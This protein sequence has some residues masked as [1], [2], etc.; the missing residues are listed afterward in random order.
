MTKLSELIT[1]IALQSGI[2]AEDSALITITGNPTLAAIE[3]PDDISSRLTAPRL[4]MDAAKQNPDLKRHFTAQALNGVDT[5][6]ARLIVEEQLADDAKGEIESE[7]NTFKKVSVLMK[8]IQ[9]K[10]S[11]KVGAA[12]KD[13]NILDKEIENLNGQLAKLK[14]DFL[15]EKDTLIKGFDS[16]RI[17]NEVRSFVLSQN[18]NLPDTFTAEAKFAAAEALFRSELQAKGINI[19]RKDGALTLQTNEGTSHFDPTTNQA[20]G[21]NDFILKTLA[22]KGAL[23]ASGQAS[24]TVPKKHVAAQ[25]AQG[26]DIATTAFGRQ[27]DGMIEEAK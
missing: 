23:K 10:E 15:A 2:S 17:N 24:P 8:K 14:T 19:V 1:A 3:V 25:G 27:L 26:F 6:I 12:T 7:V 5:E 18:L 9:Q 20:V 4:T 22:N 11:S 21:V 16:E 13:K